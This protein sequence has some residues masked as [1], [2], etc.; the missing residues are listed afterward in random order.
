MFSR[1]FPPPQAVGLQRVC[2]GAVEQFVDMK[3]DTPLGRELQRR[4][5]NQSVWKVRGCV[6]RHA[7]WSRC[8]FVLESKKLYLIL[9]WL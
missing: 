1:A 6:F 8:L 9:T 3:F 4:Q 2:Q 7:W 5:I